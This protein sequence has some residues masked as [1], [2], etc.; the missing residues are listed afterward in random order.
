MITP[1]ELGYPLAALLALVLTLLLCSWAGVWAAR[2]IY[3]I[4]R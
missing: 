2:A 1:A 4:W 3:R